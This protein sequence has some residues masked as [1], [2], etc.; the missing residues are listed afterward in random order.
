MFLRLPELSPPQ[1][2]VLH[3][4]RRDEPLQPQLPHLHQQHAEHGIPLRAAH[5]VFR[6]DLQAFLDLRPASGG[7]TVRRG[8]D[9]REDLLDIIALGKKYG[10]GMRLVT[11]GLKL[12]DPEYCEADRQEPRDDAHRLRRRHPRD[13]S[14]RCGA[15]RASS[16]SSRRRFE[17][18]CET[19]CEESGADDVRGEGV[20]RS[21][22]SGAAEVLPRP[23][24]HHPR[25]LLH[26]ARPHVGFRKVRPRSR[27]H[28]ERGHRDAGQQLLPRLQGGIRAGG[29][30]R[31]I[32]DAHRHFRG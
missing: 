24:P 31:T 21:R 26:A 12:A 4:P 11:N 18:L 7:A 2:A 5:R 6:E 8:A 16:N 9:R 13:L 10:L 14:R 19:G 28:H 30:L 25:H 17:N 15:K 1:A 3:L 27:A 20:Q 29:H 23:A 32:P 22:D